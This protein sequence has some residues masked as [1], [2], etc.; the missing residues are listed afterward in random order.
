MRVCS[1]K[2]WHRAS[3]YPAFPPPGHPARPNL[4]KLKSDCSRHCDHSRLALPFCL[5]QE[6]VGLGEIIPRSGSVLSLG[7]DHCG[8]VTLKQ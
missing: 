3:R 1:W 5:S 8:Y 4:S 2:G 6:H 7:K